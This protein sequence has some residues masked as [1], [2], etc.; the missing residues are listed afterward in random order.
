MIGVMWSSS[1]R[2]TESP[3]E[4]GDA[5]GGGGETVEGGGGGLFGVEEVLPRDFEGKND[6]SYFS[7]ARL[8]EIILQDGGTRMR[9]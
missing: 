2:I 1:S 8:V 9:L 4:T 6:L 5:E 3:V 7:Q